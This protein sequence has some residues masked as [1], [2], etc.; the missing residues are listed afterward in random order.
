MP[1][2]FRT[3]HL[4][5]TASLLDDL[6][7]LLRRNYVTFT[8]YEGLRYVVFT[9]LISKVLKQCCTYD[10][11]ITCYFRSQGNRCMRYTN[12]F[13]IFRNVEQTRTSGNAYITNRIELGSIS[14]RVKLCIL[15]LSP[16]SGLFLLR[17]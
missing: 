10:Y 6:A 5:E 8:N 14:F 16:V 17:N 13:I 15:L 7:R 9:I 1:V 4:P 11:N 12:N 3:E 2:K